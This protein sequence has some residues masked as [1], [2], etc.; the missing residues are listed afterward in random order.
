MRSLANLVAAALIAAT[1][2]QLAAQWQPYST[3]Q[4]PRRPDGKPKLDAPTPRTADGKPDLSG[5][6][7][8]PRGANGQ[9]AT[10]AQPASGPPAPTFRDVGAGFKDG[11]PFQP[12]ALEL[13]KKRQE[14]NSKDN[15]DAHC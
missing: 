5:L 11:L 7:E 9:P 1:P 2:A 3:P 15:P 12:W 10:P 6:W 13:R 4:V 8:N 14:Q